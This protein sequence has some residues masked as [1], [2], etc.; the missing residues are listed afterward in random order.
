MLQQIRCPAGTYGLAVAP[1]SDDEV[2][3][4]AARWAE[5][6][7]PVQ[8]W[9]GAGWIDSGRQVADYRHDPA[10]ALAAA[11]REACDSDEEAEALAAEAAAIGADDDH[12]TL[13]DY[14]TGEDLRAAT[15]E[16]AEA[17]RAAGPTGVILLSSDGAILELDDAGADDARRVYVAD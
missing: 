2:Y 12:G 16:E 14:L 11:L 5:A 6:S 17:S 13:T 8:V 9:G 3:A 1:W 15:A 10:A 4:V 7:S